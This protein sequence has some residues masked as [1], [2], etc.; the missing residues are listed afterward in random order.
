VLD[1]LERGITFF[2]KRYK[3]DLFYAYFLKNSSTWGDT[4][5]LGAVFKAVLGH[6][7][8]AG[9][10]LSTRP[11]DVTREV[12]DMM[13]G[14]DSITD[15][16]LSWLELGLQ[17][18]HDTTLALVNRGHNYTDFKNAVKLVQSG[19]RFKIGVHMIN[20]LPGESESDIINGTRLLF[21]ENNL[22]GIK[23][24][25]LEVFDGTKLVK[26]VKEGS[27]HL[28]EY[29]L[30]SYAKLLSLLIE[31]IP[32]GVVIMRL[33]NFSSLKRLA[34]K[35]ERPSKDTLVSAVINE[36]KSRGA[37]QGT[38]CAGTT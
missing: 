26:Q 6:P 35:G 7:Q 25:L 17:S 20:G 23:Y 36:L 15:T 12:V 19:S 27:I 3:T 32:P 30:E 37:Q 33:S 14:L 21:R 16:S 1:H 29:T 2:G 18:V 8:V 10:I 11:D 22:Q 38:S 24:R 13:S 34:S 9:L 5:H 4:G 31:E 28:P